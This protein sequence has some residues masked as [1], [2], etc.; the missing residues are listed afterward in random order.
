MSESDRSNSQGCWNCETDATGNLKEMFVD[1][2]QARRIQ[3][4]Q[5][6]ARRPV[7]LKVHGV[8][9]GRF[10]KIQ[11]SPYGILPG[12]FAMSAPL[13]AW[14]RFSSDTLPTVPDLKTTLGI[15]I[16]LFG[17]SGP[18]LI[19]DGDTSDFL[20]QNHDRF[21]VDTAT[22]MCEFTK[23]G[24]VNGSYDPYLEEHPETARILEEMKKVESSVLTTTYW[25]V[26]PY[27]FGLPVPGQNPYLRYVKYKLVPDGTAEGGQP[28]DDPNYLAADLAKRL[29][30]GEVRFK[31][32][33][34]SGIDETQTPLDKATVRWDES[35]SVPRHIATL[36]LPQQDI[37]ALGQG[38]YGE[39]LAYNPWHCLEEN[40]PLGSISDAR[41]VVYSASAQQRRDVN[42]VPSREPGSPRPADALPGVSDKCIV[43]AAIYPSIGVARLGNSQDA[44]YLGP[45][46]TDPLPAEPGSY[47]DEFGALKR[48]AARFRVYGLNVLGQPVAELTPSEDVEIVWKVHL[49]NKKSA[50]YQFQLALDIPEAASAYPS[51]LRNATI[52]D[53]SG[54][55]IDP[56]SRSIS[57]C[58][59]H[60]GADYAFDT[61]RFM[62]LEQPVYLGEI[63]TDEHGRLIV[64]GGRGVSQSYD[65]TKL[66]TFANNEGWHDDTSDGPVTATVTYKGEELRVDPA[67]VV[68]APPDYAPVQKSVRT[69][70]DLMRDVAINAG[71]LP[72][73]GRPSFQNDIRPLFERLSNLQWVNAGF[74]AAFGWQ[75]PNNLSTPEWLER[76]S[77]NNPNDREMRRTICHQFR[78]QRRDSWAAQPWPW[79]YGDAMGGIPEQTPRQNASLTNTQ[80]AMLQQW[81]DGNFEADYDPAPPVRKVEDLPVAEQPAMLTK[82]ALDFCLADAFHPGCEMTWPVR[83]SMMY[84]SAFRF[85]HAAED[86]IEPEYGAEMTGDTLSLPNGPL[87]GQVPGGV[88]RWMAIP[89]QA[90]TAS[91]RSGYQKTY[92]PYLP[93]FWPARVPNQV[94]TRENYDVVMDTELPM[95]ERMAA[96]ANRAAWLTPLQ[97]KTYTEQINNMVT[98]FGTLGVIEQRPGPGDPEFPALMQWKTCRRSSGGRASS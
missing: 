57:G 86:W 28:P 78:D 10:E 30:A 87:A 16:K 35:V 80:L 92:D 48:Q 90:D 18:K 53:R 24:V 23:A 12:V 37:S 60:G 51:L 81:A 93:T 88:T 3:Q 45:E 59:I 13:T 95:V 38:N 68:V 70:W 42:G 49:A 11:D 98:S 39:N 85:A 44:F 1:I 34:Q 40:K 2:V 5:S 74:A 20:M 8:A 82:A 79:V 61:G 71:Q 83:N 41:R 54:L 43:K 17:V 77:K 19:G 25:S 67:W 22:D 58:D 76:L 64:L 27:S 65:D 31:F 56:G 69:M 46:V 9:H 91:C 94:L 14:V 26:L 55:R 15:G 7:F 63:R 96:F 33:V 29:R 73:P 36:V 47:R 89:W 6:P 52:S 75:G 72:A 32:M 62:T 66:I 4:G 84:M 21:F 97:G 50:W